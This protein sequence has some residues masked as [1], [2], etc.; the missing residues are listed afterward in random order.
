MS[1]AP[2]LFDFEGQRLSLTEI[3]NLVPYMSR[4]GIRRHI[5]AGRNTRPQIASFDPKAAIRKAAAQRNAQRKRVN[6][7][8]G[9]ARW[10]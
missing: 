2:A 6:I 1:K 5:E 8:E 10:K 9:F 4:E 3:R 7:G